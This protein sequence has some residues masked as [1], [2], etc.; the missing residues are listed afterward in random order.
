MKWGNIM[1]I[2]ILYVSIVI[3]FFNGCTR[4]PIEIP[5]A[6]NIK[7]FLEL[8]ESNGFTY[9]KAGETSV[10]DSFLSVSTKH[11]RIDDELLAIYEYNSIEE[12]END[13]K[14]IS[15][16][17]FSIM[18]PGKNVNISWIADPYF[19]KKDLIIVNYCGE[20]IRIINF[21]KENLGDSFAGHDYKE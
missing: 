17:G 9:D 21:L 19:F 4:K 20:N 10:A 11:F 13:S 6:L 12:M 3:I 14:Y 5:N 8:L 18:Q 2:L 1:K 16:N 7:V 15:K